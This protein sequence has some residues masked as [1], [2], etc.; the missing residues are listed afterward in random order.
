MN[1]IILAF[2][3]FVLTLQATYSNI[4]SKKTLKNK[5]DIFLFNI[6][7]GFASCVTL[8]LMSGK[9]TAP[10]IFTILLAILFGLIT[11]LMQLAYMKA[12][13]CGA[14]SYSVLFLSCGMIIPTII[15][16]IIWKEP[17]DIFQILGVI[18][19]ILVFYFSAN[20]KKDEKITATWLIYAIASFLFSGIIGLLQ[21]VHQTSIHVIEINE[22]LIIA[23][24]T[25]MILSGVMY[26]WQ[27]S[28]NLVLRSF[29]LRS[30]AS[31]NAMIVG[32]CV[33][34]VNKLN[35]YL[36]GQMPSIIF[37]P[38]VNGGLIIL[39]AIVSILFFKEKMR[40]I[41]YISIL[42]GVIAIA[43]ISKIL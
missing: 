42:V 31:V 23:F 21:K 43:L 7:S 34:I 16:S 40:K 2:S 29:R 27:T 9:L 14:M 3:V 15:G 22:F 36:S 1:Y 38:L 11:L 41:Q 4:F 25:V 26:F 33:G 10:S 37:F 32:V 30:S 28:H 18:L 39:S 17:V 24:I 6:I 8:L 13:S 19:L 20:P 5:A 12:L 35:L